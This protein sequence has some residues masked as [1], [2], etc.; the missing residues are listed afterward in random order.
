MLKP[1]CFVFFGFFW[2]TFGFLCYRPLKLDFSATRK[3]NTSKQTNKN[4]LCFI[5]SEAEKHD[6]ISEANV[7]FFYVGGECTAH[8]WEMGDGETE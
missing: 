3:D 6:V 7:T 5:W 8:T 1:F 4:N 2:N